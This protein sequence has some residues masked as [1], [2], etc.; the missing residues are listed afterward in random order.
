M[1]PGAQGADARG[2]SRLCTQRNS[3]RPGKGEGAT[4]GALDGAL[5]SAKNGETES[6]VVAD[7]VKSLPLQSRAGVTTEGKALAQ[8]PLSMSPRSKLSSPSCNDD[9]CVRLL[10]DIYINRVTS[11]VVL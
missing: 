5:G 10:I 8:G 11:R 9:H 4:P 1:S 7:L 2:I 6:A 3:E